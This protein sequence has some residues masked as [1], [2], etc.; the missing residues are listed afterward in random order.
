MFHNASKSRLLTLYINEKE[1]I[2]STVLQTVFV[3]FASQL[4]A[5]LSVSMRTSSNNSNND[6]NIEY[7]SGPYLSEGKDLASKK[8]N[9]KAAMG[10]RFESM[11]SFLLD[12]RSNQ[13]SCKYVDRSF[14][15][16]RVSLDIHR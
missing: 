13:P 12:R 4:T 11:T 7:E 16:M 9:F 8:Y 1:F 14:F 5:A 6:N 3:L 15:L 2:C 10:P